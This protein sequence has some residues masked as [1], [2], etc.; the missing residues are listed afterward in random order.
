MVLNA[1]NYYIFATYHNFFINKIKKYQ[2]FSHC[3]HEKLLAH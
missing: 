1:Q 2:H 3:Y